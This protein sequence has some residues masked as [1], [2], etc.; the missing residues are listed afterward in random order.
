MDY[1][2]YILEETK[3][4]LSIDSPT[5]YTKEAAKY[6]L[7][8]YKNLGYAPVLTKKG[9]VLVCLN[10]E[11][12][13]E[14]PER[15]GILLEAHLDTLG[16]MVAEVMKNGRLKVTPL[17][18]MNANNAEAE[19]CK[20]ITRYGKKY[21]GTFQMKNASI[22]VNGDYNATKR[23]FDVMEVVIDEMVSS[24]EEVEELGIM[25][26]D[27]VCFDPRT[28]ITESGY[29][30]SRFLDDKLSVGIL[31]GYAK[32]FKEEAIISDRKIYHHITVFEEVGHGGSASVPADVNDILSVDM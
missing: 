24:K 26:G 17:G 4:I 27:I 2:A 13:K 6:V 1:S 28:V 32:Y 9:G 14:E 11:L 7:E 18:G 12:D 8:Q 31:L 5:G 19:N 25:T 22:H 10:G 23:S 30:K 15:N 16:A 3:R 20:I 21:D 29:I